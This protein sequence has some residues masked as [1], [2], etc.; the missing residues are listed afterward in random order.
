MLFGQDQPWSAWRVL[1]IMTFV[2]VVGT[3]IV[4]FGL[5]G[6]G[7]GVA[8]RRSAARAS[9]TATGYLSQSVSIIGS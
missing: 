7:H 2:I 6:I 3:V 4:V 5:G 8:P 1:V 9:V